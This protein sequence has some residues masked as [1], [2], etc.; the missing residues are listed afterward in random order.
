MPV[1]SSI[2]NLSRQ[3]SKEKDNGRE[4]RLHR[5]LSL[6]RRTK[7]KIDMQSLFQ[8]PP[9]TNTSL[10]DPVLQALQSRRPNRTHSLSPTHPSDPPGGTY[11]DIDALT[12]G[13]GPRTNSLDPESQS[14]G[15]KQFDMHSLDSHDIPI[16]DS[17]MDLAE[18]LGSGSNVDGEE[19]SFVIEDLDSSP[20]R[21]HRSSSL[22][23]IAVLDSVSTASQ[24]NSPVNASK[25]GKRGQSTSDD[26]LQS[27][28]LLL[29]WVK[30]QKKK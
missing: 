25:Q 21:K 23:H 29:S 3:L 15:M 12:I 11:V 13:M 19:E 2:E 28:K 26:K 22:P 24:D 30:E 7:N 9:I 8:A 10:N 14:L 17:L 5:S 16:H 4:D 18:G 6:P 20:G 27:R 1:S